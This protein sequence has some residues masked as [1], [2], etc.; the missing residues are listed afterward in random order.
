MDRQLLS[1]KWND[2][3]VDQPASALNQWSLNPN[4]PIYGEGGDLWSYMGIAQ[5]MG[6]KQVYN[7]LHLLNPKFFMYKQTMLE[8]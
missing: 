5:E 4:T 2:R 8:P 6:M 7:M 1:D 3:W